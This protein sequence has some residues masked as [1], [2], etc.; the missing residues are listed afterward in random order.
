MEVNYALKV[1]A[2]LTSTQ[3]FLDYLRTCRKAVNMSKIPEKGLFSISI[4]LI[5][6]ICMIFWLGQYTAILC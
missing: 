3:T 2:Q 6:L 1:N 4:C 5:C